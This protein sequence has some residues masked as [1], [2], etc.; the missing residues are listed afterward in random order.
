MTRMSYFC[1]GS[2]LFIIRSF[3]LLVSLR[4]SSSNK[5]VPGLFYSFIIIGFNHLV[6]LFQVDMIVLTDGS[7]ILGL[8]DLGVQGIGIPIGK[9]DMYVAAAGIHPQRV[10]I[11]FLILSF[12][13]LQFPLNMCILHVWFNFVVNI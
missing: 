5:L 6:S 4:T 9:L 3:V 13:Y 2:I 10:C 12:L 8:G 7:R 1:Y 11:S